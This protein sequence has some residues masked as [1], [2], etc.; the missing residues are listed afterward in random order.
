M[1]IQ[2]LHLQARESYERGDF[3]ESSKLSLL[4]V[5]RAS[6]SADAHQ[7]VALNEA[8]LNNKQ[9][10]VSWQAHAVTLEPERAELHYNHAVMLHEAN[11]SEL[12]MLSYRKCLLLEP[13][14]K[15]ALWN[16]G[17]LLRTNEHFEAAITCFEKLLQLQAEYPGL[18]HRLAVALNGAQQYK[19]AEEHF[20]LALASA[21]EDEP[22][23]R[24]EFS[25]LLLGLG[26][27]E[28]G[29]RA[30]EQRYQISGPGKIFVQDFDL[31]F[32]Q[33]ESLKNKRILIHG[34]QGLGDEIM[35]SSLLPNIIDEGGIIVLACQPPL[36]RLFA[37][38]FPQAQVVPHTA[39]SAPA[40][41]ANLGKIDFHLPLCSLALH[42]GPHTVD[43]INNDSTAS[44]SVISSCY[45]KTNHERRNWFEQQ[46]QIYGRTEAKLRVGLMWSANPALGSDWGSR[47]SRQKSLPIE[48]LALLSE[49][50]PEIDFISL[51]NIDSAHQAAHAPD[52]QLLDFHTAL[53]D[54]ADTAALAS[55]LDLVITVD[56]S[57]AHMAGGL[58]IP[59]W[60]LLKAKPDW[61]WLNSG[62]SSYWYPSTRLFRQQRMHDWQPVMN[63]VLAELRQHISNV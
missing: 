21:S 43:T 1:N 18:H 60:V 17:D 13:E 45:L 42:C 15:D 52:L 22:I 38:S 50:Q 62:T 35:F 5:Q 4:L 8:S 25:H 37:D 61:R 36:C 48:N 24:W 44:Q 40:N 29:W 19:Q 56:T 33:G 11:Q 58:G 26:R 34:E 51:Q 46:L 7:L 27:L 54:F 28:E 23:T 49:L 14:H 12:A 32:W 30:Y 3:V 47:R 20:K 63:E 10:A 16:Y 59:N 57:V 31:P 53:Q 6:N 55:C 39:M 9:Q 41:L 2:E